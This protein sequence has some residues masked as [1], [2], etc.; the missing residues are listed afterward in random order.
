MT[1]IS[2]YLRFGGDCRAA[3]TFYQACLGGDLNMQ[4]VGD[5]A[6]A[7]EMPPEIHDRIIHATL[8]DGPMSLQGSDMAG[9]EGLISGNTIALSLHCDSEEALN[10]AYASLS[11][12]GEATFAPQKEFWGGMF[13]TL[14]DKYGV[15]WLL[16][17]TPMPGA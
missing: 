17:Y 6:V 7:D 5:S 13:G 16:N 8:I 12:G 2:A 9:P 4:S 3:M 15:E 10:A 14:V 1:Q 11:V